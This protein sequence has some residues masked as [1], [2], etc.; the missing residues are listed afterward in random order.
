MNIRFNTGLLLVFLLLLVLSLFPVGCAS[1]NGDSV[2][3][4]SNG[5]ITLFGF[6]P[7]TLDP[8]IANTFLS[9]DYIVNM[10]SGLVS[11]DP[12]LNLTPEI[13]ETWDVSDD[14]RI[15]TFHL[16]DGVRF[17]DGKE[18][19]A[20]DFK[21]SMERACDP[22]TGSQTAGT[23]LGDIVGVNEKLL[24]QEEQIRGISV[25]DDYTLEITIDA[26]KEY[27]LSKLAHPVAYVVDQ[28]NVESG[29]YWWRN[30][31]GTGPFRLIEWER[32]NH[33][34]LEM[35]EL[36][37]LNLPRIEEVIYLLYAGI[38][39]RM[40]ETGQIDVT[41]VSLGDIERVLDPDNPLNA[42]LSITPQLSLFYIGFNST[43]PPFDD[44]KVRQAFCY[45]I[46]K[47]KLVKLVLQN[48]VGAAKGILPPGM[49]GFNDDLQGIPCDP[50][51]ARQMITES[52]YGDVSNL[53]PITLTTDGRGIASNLELALV[54]MWRRNL[55]VEVGIRQLEPEKYAYLLMQEKDNLFTLGW[56]ADYPDPQNFLDVLFHSGAQYNFGEYFNVEA[57]SLLESAREEKDHDARMILYRKAEETMVN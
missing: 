5:K 49:P 31:N 21:Y 3:G 14:G 20:F 13:A 29:R 41:D 51:S 9:L 15:Y 27:F 30:P 33:M 37:Y 43:K 25:I 52:D 47:D 4:I 23:F 40:Y 24:G 50:E 48:M 1:D 34:A 38:P 56:G 10:F 55:G 44:D 2:D 39:I 42:Q 46:D 7:E 19:N 6:D 22:I 8:A 36:Y 54:D 26:P 16:R 53:P 45:A 35:N 11:F 17:H 12:E 57:D 18:V 28:E 32:N